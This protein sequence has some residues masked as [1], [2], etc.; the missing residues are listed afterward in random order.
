[1]DIENLMRKHPGV[2]KERKR[3]MK[4]MN[5]PGF[6]NPETYEKELILPSHLKK[7]EDQFDNGLT[8]INPTPYMFRNTFDFKWDK[9]K[10]KSIEHL[11]QSEQVIEDHKLDTPERDGGVTTVPLLGCA[12]MENGREVPF[13]PPHE[14][15]EMAD[16]IEW[17]KPNIDQ[18][19]SAW[20]LD[21]KMMKYISMSWMNVHPKGA[22]TD[23]HHHHNVP[24]AIA[25]YLHVPPGSGNLMIKNPLAVHNFSMPVD[26][27]YYEKGMEWDVIP[28]KTGDVFFFP[29]WLDHKTE[30]NETDNDRYIMSINVQYQMPQAQVPNGGGRDLG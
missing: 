18:V 12:K 29:G 13:V 9:I 24:V 5:K 19:W 4:E 30:V 1:M 22:Y 23:K 17:V 25:C 28:V 16:F 11:K 14:W 21:F 15:P 20:K 27:E 26:E 10:D 8:T 7:E 6:I 2:K 3:M